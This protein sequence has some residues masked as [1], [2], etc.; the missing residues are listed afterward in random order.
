MT[1]SF[2]CSHPNRASAKHSS[3]P[4][5]D[6]SFWHAIRS[7]KR[8]RGEKTFQAPKSFL[9]FRALKRGSTGKTR[10]DKLTGAKGSPL[11][12]SLP[13]ESDCCWVLAFSFSLASCM[14]AR[15]RWCGEF[16][17]LRAVLVISHIYIYT[18]INIHTY[19]KIYIYIFFSYI[20]IFK[21]IFIYILLYI[22]IYSYIYIYLF[23]FIYMSIYLYSY[24]YSYI[25]IFK[26]IN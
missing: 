2:R 14:R 23:I 24:I 26:Y 5:L 18:Y 11:G 15:S 19:R 20:Y 17:F 8:L 16:S 3:M 25:Y 4:G 6:S 9:R 7:R 21:Y 10:Q 1:S 12:Q 13:C 22:Y